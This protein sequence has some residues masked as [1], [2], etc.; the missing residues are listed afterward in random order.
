MFV[1]RRDVVI[2]D[3]Y[4]VVCDERE[5]ILVTGAIHADVALHR[6]PILEN[7]RT[8]AL[9]LFHVRFTENITSARCLRGV[10]PFG[11]L[12]RP[13]REVNRV[14]DRGNLPTDVFPAR[15]GAYEQ[16]FFTRER[17]W[18]SVL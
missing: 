12:P 6:R 15:H 2:V 4:N 18:L 7:H 8:I 3:R 11:I 9:E 10:G 1:Q 17:V 5:M 13:R 16:H 14:R